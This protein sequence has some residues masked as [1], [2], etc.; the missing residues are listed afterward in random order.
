MK[1]SIML[2]IY[3]HDEDIIYQYINKTG[4]LFSLMQELQY[5]PE[6]LV[7]G[8]HRQ[9][10]RLHT[11]IVLIA[12]TGTSKTYKHLDAKIRRSEAFRSAKNK[13]ILEKLEETQYKVSVRTDEQKGFDKIIGLSYSLKEYE[14]NKDM[15]DDLDINNMNISPEQLE[16]FRKNANEQYKVALAFRAKQEKDKANE[17]NSKLTL[18]AYLDTQIEIAH[19]D[20]SIEYKIRL[21]IKKILC[22]YKKEDKTFRINGLKDM[23]CNYLYTKGY[24]DED[25]IITLIHF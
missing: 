11:H 8:K 1:I 12:D 19:D 25:Q 10:S 5:T 6:E 17:K 4:R 15:M 7:Y 21:V 13:S 14:T 18:Y 2:T 20:N 16:A 23:A 24:I 22:Y 9:A 3:T